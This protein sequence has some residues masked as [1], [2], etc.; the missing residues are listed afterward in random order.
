MACASPTAPSWR[1]R[2]LS[3]RYITD[4]FLPDKAID[5]MDE[6]GSRL[7]MQIDS[8]PE[9]LDE[10]D[11]R[12]MQLKIEREALKKETDKASQRPAGAL[13]K[14]L[15]DLED[16]S[17]A[18]TAKWQEE[19]KSVA[20]VQSAE[21]KAGRRPQEV[22]M[23]Q[24]KGDFARAGE[25]TYGVIPDLERKLK[26]IEDSKDDALAAEA[27]TAENI[28]QVVS[29]WTGIPVDKMLEGEREKLLH[30]EDRPGKARGRPGRGGARHLQCGAPRPRRP[31]GPQ[32]ADRLLPVPGPHRRRQDRADQGAG[33]VPVR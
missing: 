30:M 17:G 13:E 3:N 24:R 8:K 12:I 22:E 18:L 23:A 29:R 33:R 31:A 5:L 21:G 14:E 11:R 32:P 2:R 1:R 27:V 16:E 15:G 26:A 9:K 7:R 4:R 19:K 25:L 28:A 6:A 20:D 10:L